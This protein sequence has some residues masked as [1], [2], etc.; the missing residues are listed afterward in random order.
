MKA[1]CSHHAP[2]DGLRSVAVVGPLMM[3]DTLC[4]PANDDRLPG[5]A[6][7]LDVDFVRRRIQRSSNG[8]A[9]TVRKCQVGAVR[10]RPGAS[11][12]ASYVLTDD[13]SGSES[14]GQEVR[15]YGRCF[16]RE[17]FKSAL[18]FVETR[19]WTESTAGAPFVAIPEHCVIL[20][21]Y[22]NDRR[23]HGLQLLRRPDVLKAFLRS[24]LP[25]RSIADADVAF[26]VVRYKPEQC[27]V[28]RCAI[29][30]QERNNGTSEETFY[31]RLFPD[32]RGLR[33]YT[34]MSRLALFAAPSG[35]NNPGCH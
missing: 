32:D 25:D 26:S 29:A 1:K 5:L 21:A 18:M 10:Y 35:V 28:V 20:F 33:E 30:S 17:E 2:R 11:C 8:R 31:L 13:N 6:A 23:L 22:P 27:A 3:T 9:C 15:W 12:L 14:T 7:L 19:S 4:S 24:Q 16:L 34:T